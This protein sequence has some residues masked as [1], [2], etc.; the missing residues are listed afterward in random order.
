MRFIH[1][2]DAHLADNSTFSDDFGSFIRKNTWQSF[3]NIFADNKD[4]DFALIAGDLFERSYFSSKDFARLFAIFEDFSKDIYYVTGNHDYFD[5]HNKIFLG[6]KP[7]NLH[8]FTSESLSMFENERVRIYGLSYID[9]I[10]ARDFP[11]DISLDRDYFNILLAHADI[12]DSPTNYLNLD[13]DRLSQIGFDYVGLGHIHK[14]RSY[15]NIHYPS[16][17]EP[18]SFADRGDFGYILYDDGKIKRINS[19]L[20]E[21]KNFDLSYDDF[22]DEKSLIEYVN[23]KLGDKK[24]IVRLNIRSKDSINSKNIQNHLRA[25][26]S[27]V[28]IDQSLDMENLSSLY[29]NTLLSKFEESLRN[30]NDEISKLALKLGYDAILRSKK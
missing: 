27:Y 8:I 7:N 15:K 1:L 12:S 19:N 14:A 20:M 29:P 3:E 28:S 6:Q 24:N 22:A 11:Y 30:K 21:F 9:R 18:R 10:Y 23:K 2:A 13:R 5:S 26:F 17:I 16:S 4:V 25:D